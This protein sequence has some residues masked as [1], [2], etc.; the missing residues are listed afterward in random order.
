MARG[1]RLADLEDGQAEAITA[2][3]CGKQLASQ[4]TTIIVTLIAYDTRRIFV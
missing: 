4:T 3:F 2:L 1:L